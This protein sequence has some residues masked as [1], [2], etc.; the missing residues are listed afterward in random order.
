M[1]LTGQPNA[2]PAD[3]LPS[4]NL[5]SRLKNKDLK[6]TPEQVES[7]LAANRRNAYSLLAA[8][9]I[10]GDPA[11]L[12]EAM[13][14]YPRDPEVALD[15]VFNKD[16]S[17]EEQRQWLEAF[18]QSAP[19]NALANYLSALNY[20]KTGQTDQGVQDLIA[21]SNKPQFQDYRTDRIQAAEE[22]LSSA[23]PVAEA[24]ALAMYNTTLLP[25]PG[26]LRELSRDVVDLANSYRQAGDEA[27]AQA[28]LQIAVNLGQNYAAGSVAGEP[29]ITQLAGLSVEIYALGAMN[30]TSPFG[31]NGQT[32]QDE[33]NQ[34]AQQKAALK[35][36]VPQVDLLQQAMTD[37]DWI[38]YCDR[39]KSS[40][41]ASAN[42]WL[43][44]KYGQK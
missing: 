41:E 25:Q 39:C 6:L 33:I 16:A 37:Q 8:Y 42:Q 9:C 15:A 21:A 30:P 29:L 19:D 35:D 36:G 5:Y 43:I 3:D 1:R 11:L 28:A 38:S 23:Y 22:I 14:Q 27:S 7:Y 12:A 26:S 18:K 31:A 10:T 32:V 4:A 24:E 13:R 44:G 40:G 17:P 2:S 34:L 20:F